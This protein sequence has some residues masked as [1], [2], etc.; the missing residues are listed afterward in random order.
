MTNRKIKNIVVIGGG[1]GTYTVLTA[2]T[3]ISNIN[4]TAIVAST[5]SGG[6]TGILRDEF[7]CLPVGDF[8]QCLVALADRN[9]PVNILRELF[10]YRFEKGGHGLEGHNFGNLFITAL[11]EIFKNEEAA[12]EY[13]SKI[14]N[15]KGS[16]YPVTFNKIQLLAKY[17]NGEILFGQINIDDPPINHDGNLKIK[18]LWSQPKASVYKK[19]KDAIEKADLILLGPGDLYTS[20]I[21]N[22]VIDDMPKIIERSKAKIL[23][24]VN[25][26]T[27]YGQTHGYTSSMHV[28]ELEKYIKTKVDYILINNKSLPSKILNKYYLEKAFP[29]LDDL[30]KDSRAKYANL[31]TNKLIARN[32]K[33]VI[34]RSLIRHDPHKLAKVINQ[35]IQ[36]I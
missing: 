4:I 26:V 35:I 27:K 32:S 5:D 1:T 28:S 20:T 17:N 10:M 2:L 22:F 23:Y 11:S 19:T 16:V 34:K 14:L 3:E 29:V 18:K 12:F 9:S 36:E 25:L 31:I 21:A 15:I 7:G 6:S 30:E 24:I 13:A 8:R 33:D